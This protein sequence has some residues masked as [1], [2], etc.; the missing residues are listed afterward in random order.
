[1]IFLPFFVDTPEDELVRLYPRTMF[2]REKRDHFKHIVKGTST[3]PLTLG[4][5]TSLVRFLRE[6]C[7]EIFWDKCAY[8]ERVA[9]KEEE[10]GVDYW[11]PAGYTI[12]PQVKLYEE[13]D[14]PW[15][16][17]EPRNV[18]YC[19]SHCRN[20]QS[21]QFP[22]GGQRAGIQTPWEV[23]QNEKP[24][25]LA[26]YEDDPNQYLEFL[27]DGKVVPKQ[28]EGA[29]RG[30]ST[31]E[32]F[33]LNREELVEER[34]QI[35]EEFRGRL[36]G[37]GD[38]TFWL[39]EWLSLSHAF[40]GALRQEFLQYIKNN[41]SCTSYQK[42]MKERV[43]AE[44][45]VIL[46]AS[47]T[48]KSKGVE[49]AKRY[50]PSSAS[51][52]R[53]E[54]KSFYP[55][56]TPLSIQNI[57]IRNFRGIRYLTLKMPH[58]TANVNPSEQNEFRRHARSTGISSQPSLLLLG[59]NGVGK[60]DVLQAIALTL[61]SDTERERLNL[62]A[63][64]FLHKK[65]QNASVEIETD[66]GTFT[67]RINSSKFS[68][69]YAPAQG[70]EGIEPIPLLVAYGTFRDISTKQETEQDVSPIFN[71]FENKDY[72][73]D[74]NWVSQNSEEILNVAMRLIPNAV[75]G[76]E[77]GSGRNIR[78]T[79]VSQDE[80]DELTLHQL[81][82]GHR[83]VISMVYDMIYR[84]QILSGIPALNR[85]ITSAIVLIDELDNHLH[86][87]WKNGILGRLREEF[88]NITFIVSTQDPCLAT[89]VKEGE[90]Q[91]LYRTSPRGEVVAAP[92]SGRDLQN[93][94]LKE[95]LNSPTFGL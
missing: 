52:D 55:K 67:L 36:G 2:D 66:K 84:L 64:E 38:Q 42:E 69:S 35:L 4:I 8:C 60:T 7:R 88:P 81:C 30:K 49:V 34:R 61:I 9:D 76:L 75:L 46:R 24:L 39:P 85:G 16:Q 21:N 15:F 18:Y 65:S 51:A 72:L 90:I 71:L 48:L 47:E 5:S 14:Y 3:Q 29:S 78:E 45:S 6:P 57:S 50:N 26:P 83:S 41:V 19:C 22:I 63:K 23:A 79:L 17:N 54:T 40:A 53:V 43:I 1:M 62:T 12:N 86:P 73:L 74:R 93:Q 20:S 44:N 91:R 87:T 68:R 11:R 27:S 56:T 82:S 37:E 89:S 10:R 25:L 92:V 28:G 31:I 80:A 95:I 58:A 13:G 77:M 70:G 32:V 33:K 94:T 59:D